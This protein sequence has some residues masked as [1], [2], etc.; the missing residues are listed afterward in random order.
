MLITIAQYDTHC[1]ADKVVCCAGL[2]LK[3]TTAQFVGVMGLTW[4]GSQL[5]KVCITRN[6]CAR[7]LHL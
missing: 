5:T 1:D 3:A 4:A 6:C 2:G 7:N